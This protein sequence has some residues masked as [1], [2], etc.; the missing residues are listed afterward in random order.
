MYV[1]PDV[2][3]DSDLN[4]DSGLSICLCRLLILRIL[5]LL[6]FWDGKYARAIASMYAWCM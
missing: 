6:D 4:S 1:R 2:G 3:M 5:I